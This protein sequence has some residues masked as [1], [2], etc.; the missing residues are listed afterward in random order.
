MYGLIDYFYFAIIGRK[1]RC[2]VQ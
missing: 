2:K 1:K